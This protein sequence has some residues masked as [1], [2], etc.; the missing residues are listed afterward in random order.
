MKELIEKLEAVLPYK[1]ELKTEEV[2]GSID[3]TLTEKVYIEIDGGSLVVQ[4]DTVGQNKFLYFFVRKYD[5][6]W[7]NPTNDQTVL[8]IISSYLEQV[9]AEGCQAVILHYEN[10]NN[11]I[12]PEPEDLE[13]LGFERHECDDMEF[14][15]PELFDA[16]L[17][18]GYYIHKFQ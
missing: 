17:P 7:R 16:H 5:L 10:L 8:T 1:C 4:A 2:H 11:S 6:F 9:K 3:K 12:F 14:E 13:K 15:T 18:R